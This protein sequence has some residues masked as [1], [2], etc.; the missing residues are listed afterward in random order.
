MKSESQIRQKVKQVVFRHRKKFVEKSLKRHPCNCKHNEEVKL[1]TPSSG[2]HI[3]RRCSHK[4]QNTLV[5]DRNLGG[6]ELAQKCPYFEHK[7]TA[8]ALK[9]QFAARLGLDGSPI[10][11]G[12]LARDFPDVVA[13]MWV[14]GS[15]KNEKDPETPLVKNSS[16]VVLMPSGTEEPEDLPDDPFLEESDE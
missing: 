5:C 6:L 1:K 12:D 9:R 16:L 15:Q 7:H 2:L 14:L 8:E 11:L 4:E 10:S 3:I 13:L